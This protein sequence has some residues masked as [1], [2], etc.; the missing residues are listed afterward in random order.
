MHANWLPG[1][2]GAGFTQL[3][4]FSYDLD[5]P[6]SAEAWRGR[7]RASAG[8]VALDDDAT[9]RFD[10]ALADLLAKSYA[11]QLQVPHRVFAIVAV[12]P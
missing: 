10:A 8:I 7:I 6:Y 9:A 1:L 3:E 2:S 11:D 5:A 4:T 12:S